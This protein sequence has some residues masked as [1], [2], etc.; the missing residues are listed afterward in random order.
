MSDDLPLDINGARRGAVLLMALNEDSAVEVFKN[1]SASEVTQLTREMNNLSRLTQDA[2]RQI[3]RDFTQEVE[4]FSDINLHP[5]EHFQ[6]VLSKALGDKRANSLFEDANEHQHKNTGIDALNL[7]EASVVAEL[8][9]D[10]H[11][12]IITT[13][14]VHLEPAQASDILEQF[15]ERLR[16]E[17]MVRIATFTGVQPAALQ[18][19]NEMLGGI[20]SGQSLKRGKMGGVKT[21]A[22]ILGRMSSSHE[23]AVIDNIRTHSEDLAQKILDEML[24]FENLQDLDDSSIQILLQEVDPES[25]MIALKGANEELMIKFMS[26]MSQRAAK[27]MCEEMD[28]KGPLRRSVVESEQK[29]LLQVVKRL[30]DSG[31][32]VLDGGNEGYV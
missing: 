19:L 4:G 5:N 15:N 28:A 21:A 13:I 20:L 30:V 31:K 8:I 26:N 12:Q 23:E 14:M 10:E 18:E 3:L 1:F 16:N 7:M 2:I 24:L 25:L 29:A 17:V 9:R 22:D 32:I 11:P 6:N 27:L